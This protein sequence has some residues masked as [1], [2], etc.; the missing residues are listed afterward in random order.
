MCILFKRTEI[1]KLLVIEFL[2]KER[3]NDNEIDRENTADID[4]DLKHR[5]RRQRTHFTVTQLQRLEACFSRNKY[6]DMTMREDI[7]QWCNLTES[8]VRVSFFNKILIL[9][10]FLYA[11]AFFQNSLELTYSF[12][13]LNKNI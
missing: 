7:A 12:P 8:R 4:P 5:I 1:N 11:S 6:P 10:L 9:T 3:Q 2:E 13:Y